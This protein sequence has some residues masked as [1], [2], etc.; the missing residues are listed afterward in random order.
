MCFVQSWNLKFQAM[1]IADWLSMCRVVGE[2]ISW[3]SSPSKHLNQTASFAACAP[4]RYSASVLKRVT[5]ACFLELQLIVVS[6]NMKVK[7]KV[8][9]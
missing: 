4:A 3:P 2:W 9:L 6:P 7:P 1:A 8:D 5:A